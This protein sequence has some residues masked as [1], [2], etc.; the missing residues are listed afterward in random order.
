MQRSSQII[1]TNKPAPSAPLLLVGRQEGHQA[2]KK[3]GAGLFKA[4]KE[5]SRLW[6]DTYLTV[7]LCTCL[8]CHKVA[9]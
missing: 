8:M 5:I 3:L 6:G 4:E 7:A 9:E 1:T 2:C